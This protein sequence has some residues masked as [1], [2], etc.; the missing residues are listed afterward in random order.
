M[1]VDLLLLVAVE[2]EVAEFEVL[3]QE[4]G[5]RGCVLFAGL[6]QHGG[7]LLGRMDAGRGQFVEVYVAAN[8]DGRRGVGRGVGR[9]FGIPATE[10]SIHAFEKAG[11]EFLDLFGSK[12]VNTEEF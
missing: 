9:G 1:L 8:G 10:A 12:G 2:V 6:T 5:K 11:T 4:S 3:A 7:E